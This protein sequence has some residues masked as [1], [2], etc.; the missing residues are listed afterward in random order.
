MRFVIYPGSLL[1]IYG[2]GVTSQ[3]SFNFVSW[4]ISAEFFAYLL[5]PIITAIIMYDVIVGLALV[6]ILLVSAIVLSEIVF[7]KTMTSLMSEFSMVRALPSFALGVW[8]A[9]YRSWLL[10]YLGQPL[11][12]WCFRISFPILVV[13]LI[14]QADDYCL[15]GLVYLVVISAFLAEGGSSNLFVGKPILSNRGEMTYSLYMLHTVIATVFISFAFP[16]IIG[17]SLAARVAAVIGG[18]VLSYVAARCSLRYFEEPA[19]RWL[20]SFNLK[21]KSTQLTTRGAIR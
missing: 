19:R 11:P 21:P 8:A 9:C 16:K 4:S 20:N 12:V 14:M 6:C 13:A 3:L 10:R 17:L 2:W 18:F 5:F 7:D 15:L 1:L